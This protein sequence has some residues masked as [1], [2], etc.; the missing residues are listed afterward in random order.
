MSV[1]LQTCDECDGA[2]QVR[3][4]RIACGPGCSV[5]VNGLLVC[6]ACR[7]TGQVNAAWRAK[8]R[9]L[10]AARQARDLGLRECAQRL[11]VSAPVMSDAEHGRID[12]TALLEK[13]T[14]R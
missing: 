13:V 10:R 1:D 7:G 5:T 9:A 11:Q 14:R 2:G 8:G 4:S 12:P 3:G 6:S